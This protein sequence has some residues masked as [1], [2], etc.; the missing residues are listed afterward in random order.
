MAE[1]GD[2]DQDKLQSEFREI[3]IQKELIMK[4]PLTVKVLQEQLTRAFTV[5][6]LI[7]GHHVILA[8][9]NTGCGKSTMLTSLVFGPDSL[10]EKVLTQDI[11]ILKK[12][13]SVLKTKKK[14]TK[15]I[16]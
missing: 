2:F 1:D 15:V 12:D 8:V 10:E 6:E 13:G 3:D 4:M 9:G 11:P 16:E 5:L 7:R 14:K